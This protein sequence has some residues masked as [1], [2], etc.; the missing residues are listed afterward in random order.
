MRQSTKG[1]IS[2]STG[3]ETNWSVR[4]FL[5]VPF[6]I[7]GLYLALVQSVNY[8]VENMTPEFIALQRN[9]VLLAPEYWSLGTVMVGIISVVIGLALLYLPGIKF[10]RPSRD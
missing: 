10:T 8:R 4:I 6:I 9:S 7:L 2:M 1:V 3:T 5:G